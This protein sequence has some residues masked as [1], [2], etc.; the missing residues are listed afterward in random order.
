MTRAIKLHHDRPDCTSA[1][2]TLTWR[3][4]LDRQPFGVATIEGAIQQARA[5]LNL[6]AHDG[7]AT[8][9]L[10]QQRTEGMALHKGSGLPIHYV[11]QEKLFVPAPAVVKN[12]RFLLAPSHP[13]IRVT[14]RQGLLYRHADDG[15][16]RFSPRATHLPTLVLLM[17]EPKAVSAVVKTNYPTRR[18]LCLLLRD[19]ENYVGKSGEFATR[20]GAHHKSGAGLVVFAFPDDHAVLGSDAL[21][22]AE[23][24][25]ISAAFEIFK[26]QNTNLGADTAPGDSDRRAGSALAQAFLA[27]AIRVSGSSEPGADGLLVW[28]TDLRGLRS[29]ANLT[30]PTDA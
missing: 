1:L 24:L 8:S 15:Q 28:R 30:D 4:L 10:R 3:F 14:A 2:R 9:T 12:W 25:A 16:L 23:S 26:L 21:S 20:V 13:D 27:A 6:K 11:R 7:G 22:V 29:Y 5:D 19:G 18:G 17:G